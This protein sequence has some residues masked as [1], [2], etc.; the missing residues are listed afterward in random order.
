MAKRTR[1]AAVPK[2]SEVV[3]S[4][5]VDEDVEPDEALDA[6]MAETP[7]LVKEAES[8]GEV[9]ELREELRQMREMLK[10]S[11]AETKAAN[12]ALAIA[13]ESAAPVMVSGSRKRPG[14]KS[15][16]QVANQRSEFTALLMQGTTYEY[17][18]MVFR[19]GVPQGVPMKYYERFKS[20]GWFQVSG[21]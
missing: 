20:N 9:S 16:R 18:G 21:V 14:G 11:M 15:V 5:V 1:K 6:E 12:D 4:E 8:G 19:R 10:E 3:E 7:E 2:E 13:R 17:L